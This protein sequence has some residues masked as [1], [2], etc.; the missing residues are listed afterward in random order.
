ML[1][2][3]GSVL[4][5][6]TSAVIHSGEQN[7]SFDAVEANN[8]LHLAYAAFCNESALAAWDCQWCQGPGAYTEP[9]QLQTYLKDAKVGVSALAMQL[10][11]TSDLANATERLP[12]AVVPIQQRPAVPARARPRCSVLGPA[13]YADVLRV[14]AALPAFS[15]YRP[16]PKGTSR[17]IEHGS[18]WW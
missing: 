14:A 7:T 8:T 1:G 5:I 16:G 15:V 12:F 3:P 2:L 18:G 10:H 17:W 9:M 13:L 6:V 4:A 11:S